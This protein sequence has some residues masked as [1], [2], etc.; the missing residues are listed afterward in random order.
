M[1]R[2]KGDRRSLSSEVRGSAAGNIVSLREWGWRV[3][4]KNRWNGIWL[5]IYQDPVGVSIYSPLAVVHGV[6]MNHPDWGCYSRWLITRE[7]ILKCTT[8]R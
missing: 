6:S 1:G 7:E 5:N 8:N 3:L 4:R 2:R